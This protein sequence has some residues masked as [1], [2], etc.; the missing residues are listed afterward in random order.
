MWH[1]A[2]NWL[3]R[4]G[5]AVITATAADGYPISVRQNS[6]PYDAENGEMRVSIPLNLGVVA[7]SANLLAH[8]HDENL[9]HLSAIQIKGPLEQRSTEWVFVSTSFDNPPP[10][11]EIRRLWMLQRTMRRSANRYLARRGIA[12]P[13]VDW[14]VINHLQRQAQCARILRNRPDSPALHDQ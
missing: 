13:K 11:G 3:H 10:S 12:R 8:R 14:A 9:W 1:Q 5:S 6:L 2:A 7:G 4:F